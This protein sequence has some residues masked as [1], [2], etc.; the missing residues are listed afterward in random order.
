MVMDASLKSGRGRI[1]PSL[2]RPH[3]LFRYSGLGRRVELQPLEKPTFDSEHQ[4]QH[5]SIDD[6]IA[7]HESR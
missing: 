6:L 5:S 7:K 3:R 2:L 4:Q 1:S